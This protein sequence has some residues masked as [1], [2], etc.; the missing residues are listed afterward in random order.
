[1]EIVEHT[2][3]KG[4]KYYNKI[5]SQKRADRIKELF[6][7]KGVESQRVKSIGKGESAPIK[8]CDTHVYHN[9]LLGHFHLYQ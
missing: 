2:D 7:S 1:M 8:D 4:A 5:L 3:N 6:V 9:P